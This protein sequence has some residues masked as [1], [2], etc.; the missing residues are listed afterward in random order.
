[1]AKKTKQSE[2]LNR[3]KLALAIANNE[4]VQFPLQNHF[5]LHR[6]TIWNK[7]NL[8]Q[9]TIHCPYLREISPLIVQFLLQRMKIEELISY[10]RHV[11]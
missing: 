1:M 11:Q 9:W 10:S 6:L 2:F 4:G 7:G 5:Q 8:Q 3:L